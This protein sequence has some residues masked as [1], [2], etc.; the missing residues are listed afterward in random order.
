MYQLMQWSVTVIL[1]S[2]E[3]LAQLVATVV[4][5]GLDSVGHQAESAPPVVGVEVLPPVV[6][7]Y[8]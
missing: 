2:P 7:L 5:L 8:V 3:L 1:T 4:T 6:Q